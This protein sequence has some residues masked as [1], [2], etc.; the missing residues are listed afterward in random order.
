MATENRIP[1]SFN[2]RLLIVSPENGGI[3]DLLKFWAFNNQ[4]SGAKFLNSSHDGV[5]QQQLLSDDSPDHRWVII[6]SIIVRK[7]IA[8]F[9]KPMEWIGCIVEFM[10]NLFS[11]NGNFLGLLYNFFHGM[12]LYFT[13]FLINSYMTAFA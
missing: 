6:V 3:F 7:I 4:E 11:L 13:L 9:G 10:L 1:I 8:F 12:I 5:I 2:S